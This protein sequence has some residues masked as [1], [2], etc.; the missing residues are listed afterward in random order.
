MMYACP[1]VFIRPGMQPGALTPPPSC[2]WCCDA[3]SIQRCAESPGDSLL[4]IQGLRLKAE[5]S[6]CGVPPSPGRP[7]G[8]CL[9]MCMLARACTRWHPSI[10][11]ASRLRP[12]RRQQLH[13]QY[14][15]SQPDP[16]AGCCLQSTW[17]EVCCRLGRAFDT[18]PCMTCSCCHGAGSP[19]SPVGLLDSWTG[20][21]RPAPA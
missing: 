4:Q 7:A 21:P 9:T 1:G 20:P 19:P 14:I 18:E 15:P 11:Q 8:H 6:G 16:I 3:H 10:S 17:Q 13:A 12:K 5:G 2:C